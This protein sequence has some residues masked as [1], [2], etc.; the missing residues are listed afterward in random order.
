MTR[1]VSLLAFGLALA[2]GIVLLS[3]GGL[4]AVACF[5]LFVLAT[6]PGLPLGFALFGR[7]HGAGW[8]TGALLGYATSCLV[9]WAAVFTHPPSAL[10]V[11]LL[12]LA[13]VVLSLGFSR[14]IPRA[15]RAALV[16]LPAWTARDTT[17]LLVVRTSLRTR[18]SA[19]SWYLRLR[20]TAAPRS[21]SCR[22]ALG[23]T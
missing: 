5:A 3:I 19:G 2:I 11:V 1:N 23:S 6:V 4:T 16:A 8:I 9:V 15:G 12:W 7:R 18:S 22:P 17:A 20:P 10:V 13:A 21:R 14:V